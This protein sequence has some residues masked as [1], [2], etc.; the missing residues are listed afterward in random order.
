SG[1]PQ[2]R[3]PA[4]T[5]AAVKVFHLHSTHSAS[6]RTHDLRHFY[7]SS[8][9]KANLNPKVIQSRLGHATIAETMDTYG[10]LFPDD[11]DPGRGAI[12]SMIIPALAEQQRNTG[13]K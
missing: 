6:R 11:E 5:R 3:L 12:E 10:H 9:I 1:C 13:T 8:L 7:A 4:A 2:L